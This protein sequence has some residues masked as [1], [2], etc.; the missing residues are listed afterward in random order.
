MNNIG[1]DEVTEKKPPFLYKVIETLLP[2]A[3][4]H[5]EKNPHGD[6]LIEL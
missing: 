5:P 2:N 3:V 4:Y 1:L 6:K